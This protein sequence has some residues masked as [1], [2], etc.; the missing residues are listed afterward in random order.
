ML[1]SVGSRTCG[2][3]ISLG[4]Q[5][6]LGICPPND[7]LN[8]HA[9]LGA[10]SALGAQSPIAR[11]HGPERREMRDSETP[12]CRRSVPYSRYLATQD[13]HKASENVKILVRRGCIPR[14]SV[15]GVWQLRKRHPRQYLHSPSDFAIGR[16]L[17][18]HREPSLFGGIVCRRGA[19]IGVAGH[20]KSK[21]INSATAKPTVA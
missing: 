17:P 14:G 13:L 12:F 7:R 19:R 15:F 18:K 2:V 6:P 3:L 9:P 21:V 11:I 4:Y 20:S 16:R 10:G 8:A 5:T 1:S